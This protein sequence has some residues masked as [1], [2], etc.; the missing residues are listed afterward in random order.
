[1]MASRSFW[2]MSPCIDETVKLASRIFSVSQSTLRFV[3]QKMTAWVMVR[4]REARKV[5]G[6]EQMQHTHTHRQRKTDARVV[7][8]AERVKLPVLLLDGDKELLDALKRQLV[9]LDEDPD[10]VRH[11]LGRH[12]KHVVRE[13]RRDDDDLRRRRQ[14]A[15]DVVDLVLEALVEKLISLIEDEH[16][17][18]GGTRR[19]KVSSKP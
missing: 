6:T 15:V 11:E 8:I 18:S 1:M 17:E 16:L 19:T 5:R 10:R 2:T 7:E 9:A 13:R 4:L 12:L 14:V 3:L